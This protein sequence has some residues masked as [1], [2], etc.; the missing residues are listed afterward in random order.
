MHDGEFLGGGITIQLEDAVATFFDSAS[1]YMFHTDTEGYTVPRPGRY[2]VSV[3]AYPYQADTTVTLTL[4][5]GAEGVAASAN[6]TDLIGVFDLTGDAGRTV[7]VTTFLKPGDVVSPSV[8]DLKVPPGSYVNYFLPDENVRDYTGEG[9]AIKWLSVEGPLVDAWPPAGT[10]MLL[11]DLAVVDGDVKL[12]KAPYEH[13]LDIVADF[14]PVAFRRPLVDGEAEAYAKLAEPLLAEGRPFIDALRVPLRAVL[15]AP[16]FLFHAS[17]SDRLDE[18]G[19]ATRLS[20]FL[21]RSMPDAELLE[22]AGAGWLSDPEVLAVQVERMLG[23]PRSER[24]VKDFAGQL[25]DADFT[26]VNRR[27]AEHYRIPEITGQHMRKVTLAEDSVRGGLLAQAAIHKLTANGTT[28]S[29]VPRGNFV[30]ANLLGQPAPPPPPNVAGLEPDTR[31]TTTIREQLTAH[32][33]NPMCATCHTVIDPPGLA[34]ESFDPIGGFRTSYRAS[35]KE[36]E[37]N[38]DRYPGPYTQGLPVD[39]SGVTPEGFTFSGF[40]DYQHFLLEEKLDLVARQMVSQLLVLATGAEVQF[41]DRQDRDE[42]VSKL[43]AKDYPLR[44]MIHEVAQSDLFRRQ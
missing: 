39:P 17:E 5:K 19:L 22:V 36:I 12:V 32:R 2:R 40:K 16:S 30:L 23:D 1:T 20:Y 41:A 8:A 10:R 34:L 38:G 44:T 28:S 42:I 33:Q 4:F 6:L 18:F 24:F 9:I 15:S 37:V 26:F 3:A 29:P 14:A 27:L 43:V 7:E 35:G 11:G 25:V 21:W 31:G 13:V